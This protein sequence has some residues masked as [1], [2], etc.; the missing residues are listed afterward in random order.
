MRCAHAHGLIRRFR[1]DRR[2]VAIIEFALLAPILVTL[3]LGS[4]ELT[5]AFQAQ[6]RLAHLA[7][8]MADMASQNRTITTAEI[9][10]ILAAGTVMA[11]P[12]SPAPLGQRIASVTAGAGGALTVDWQRSR[13]YTA[14]GAPTTPSGYLAANESVIVADVTY[15]YTPVFT[16]ILPQT[17][18]FERRAYLRP[19]LSDKVDLL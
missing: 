4:V 18:R 10:D 1:D 15:D 11:H 12:L 19:R 9:D 7:Q 16:L 3:Y 5:L 17:I 13:Q 14:P 6:Q 8:A 2:G